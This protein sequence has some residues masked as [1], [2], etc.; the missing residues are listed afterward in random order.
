MAQIDKLKQRIA[1]LE[2]KFD[3]IL[4]GFDDIK[5]GI[6]LIE[7]AFFGT[8]KPL[9]RD[10]R[11]AVFNQILRE[12]KQ[13]QRQREAE[14]EA[15]IQAAAKAKADSEAKKELITESEETKDEPVVD[16][17]V[18]KAMEQELNKE[19]VKVEHFDTTPENDKVRIEP[20][21]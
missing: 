21:E 20:I 1:S 2:K 7:F 18:A 3:T 9:D 11:T 15:M 6:T 4:A 19:E 16:E 13:A 8:E 17:E 5:E 12:R 14:R 10:G